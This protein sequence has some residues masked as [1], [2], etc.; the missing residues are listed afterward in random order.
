MVSYYC[1]LFACKVLIFIIKQVF[2]KKYDYIGKIDILKC[3]I[4]N[5]FVFGLVFLLII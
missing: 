3:H 1:R 5:S 2:I 4:T